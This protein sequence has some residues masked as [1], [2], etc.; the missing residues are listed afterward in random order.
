MKKIIRENLC[1]F[2]VKKYSKQHN[3]NTQIKQ[4][5]NKKS[6]F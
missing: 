6:N 3:I 2:V 4:F 1:S 5:M